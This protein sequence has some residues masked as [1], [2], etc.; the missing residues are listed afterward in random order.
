MDGRERTSIVLVWRVGVEEKWRVQ[1]DGR[2]VV[3]IVVGVRVGSKGA[4]IRSGKLN[5]ILGGIPAAA[6]IST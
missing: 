4:R 1:L 2:D 3:V 6:V 5:V